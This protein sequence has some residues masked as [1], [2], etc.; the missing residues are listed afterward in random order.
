MTS[1]EAFQRRSSRAYFQL[2]GCRFKTT[3]STKD[4]TVQN[5]T[6]NKIWITLFQSRRL[7]GVGSLSGFTGGAFPEHN[8]DFALKGILV[9]HPGMQISDLAVSIDEQSHRQ[10]REAEFACQVPIANHNGVVDF[11]LF[12][13]GRH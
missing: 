11:F 8:L 3:T 9:H 2:L 4:R 12:K 13:E 10:R 1:S 5:C 6:H 7:P